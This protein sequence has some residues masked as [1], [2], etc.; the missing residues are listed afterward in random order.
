MKDMYGIR[1]V[2]SWGRPR[3]DAENLTVCPHCGSTDTEYLTGGWWL[4]MDCDEQWN[5]RE[6][7]L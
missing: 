6:A 4:C 3:E 1:Q 7:Q 5:E 2:D